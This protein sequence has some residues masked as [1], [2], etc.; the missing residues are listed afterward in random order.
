MY[1]HSAMFTSVKQK[2]RNIP[3]MRFARGKCE[4]DTFQTGFCVVSFFFFI[5]F[6]TCSV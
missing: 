2:Q 4:I 3:K 6:T 5:I 1:T